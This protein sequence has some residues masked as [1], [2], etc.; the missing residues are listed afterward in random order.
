MAWHDGRPIFNRLPEKGYKDNPVADA[1]TAWIDTKLLAKADQL[2]GFYRNLDPATAE[3]QYLDYL[4]WLVGL[5]GNYWDFA[6]SSEV[7]RSLIAASHN[8]LWAN[9]GTLAVIL[10]VLA[11]HGI[12]HDV[13]TDEATVLPF[14][15]PRSFGVSQL[16]VFIRLPLKYPRLGVDWLEAQRTLNNYAPAIVQA[17]VCY[18]GF[19]LGFSKL[20]DPLWNKKDS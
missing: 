7:K 10:F 16:R 12:A 5:S 18:Q 13:R 3:E 20:G 1:L 2:Q 9:R 14:K 17:R 11:V 19:K 15:M 6:W 8:F 4:A